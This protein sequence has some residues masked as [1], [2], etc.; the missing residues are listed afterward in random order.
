[1]QSL[2]KRET[3]TIEFKSDREKGY[4]DD[5]LVDEIV[6]MTNAEGGILYLG[7]EDDGSVTGLSESHKDTIRTSAVIANK[8]R[9]SLSVRAEILSENGRQVMA[10]SVP[11]SNSVVASASGKILKRLLK[12]D[13]SPEV[14]PMYPYEI[15]TRLSDLRKLDFS[16]QPIQDASLEDFDPH[17]IDR[18]RSTIK[19]H[20][21]DRN[22]LELTDEEMEQALQLTAR[23]GEH[24]YPT[25]AGMLLLGREERLQLLVPTATADFQVLKGTNVAVNESYHKPILELIDLFDNHIKAWNPEQELEDG[26]LR[27]PIPEFSPKA[28]REGLMNAIVHRDYSILGNVRVM[29][30]DE[31]MTIINPGGFIEGV[32]I[33]NLLTVEPC[34]RNPVLS[35]ALK[36]IGLVER[37]GRGIDRI[38]EGSISFGRPWPDYSESTSKNIVLFIPRGKAD[39]GFLRLLSEEQK[40]NNNPLSIYALMILSILKD[41]RKL[42]NGEL[43]EFTHFPKNRLAP[44]VEILIER[45]LIE[46]FGHGANRMLMLSSRVYQS[47]K[48]EKEYIRQKGIDHLRF[49]EMILNLA[50]QQGGFVTKRDVVQLLHLKESQAYRQL[51]NLCKEHRIELA[52]GGKYSKYKLIQ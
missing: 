30:D 20:D 44:T 31:G 11:K 4:S 2:P 18:L 7:I 41:R 3:L 52:Q 1:M 40:N 13:G 14:V 15:V 25:L 16:A 6:G 5:K 19:K 49:Q 42:N 28:F 36:R 8:T 23:V 50:K 34:G 39:A 17:Q 27:I 26:L 51:Q 43:A 24:V 29:I 48:K 38:F 45:G 22:L 32:S 37:T 12:K 35:D 46:E 21:G 33:D 10:I 9:P 47:A